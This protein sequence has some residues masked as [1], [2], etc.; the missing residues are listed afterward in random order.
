M[1]SCWEIKIEQF[2]ITKKALIS[3]SQTIPRT[4]LYDGCRRH[5]VTYLLPHRC[6]DRNRLPNIIN[7]NLFAQFNKVMPKDFVNYK[8]S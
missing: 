5:C 7:L 3:S 2:V 1:C 6:L 4:T 8:W